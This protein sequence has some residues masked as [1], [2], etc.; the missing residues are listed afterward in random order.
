MSNTLQHHVRKVR[1][2]GHSPSVQRNLNFSTAWH[3]GRYST[4]NPGRIRDLHG[5]TLYPAYGDEWFRQRCSKTL[6]NDIHGE[7]SVRRTSTWLDLVNLRLEIA[8]FAF[9]I[10]AKS[11][12]HDADIQMFPVTGRYLCS[13]AK[14]GSIIS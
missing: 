7:I 3:A 13:S 9:R 8:E 4:S 11:R 10:R 14:S 2:P 1:T 5:H 12:D 6:S